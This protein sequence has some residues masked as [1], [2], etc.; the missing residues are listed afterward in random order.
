MLTKCLFFLQFVFCFSLCLSS[1]SFLSEE[2]KSRLKLLF[3]LDS[4][5]IDY[6]L[7]NI[8]YSL[9]GSSILAKDNLNSVFTTKEITNLCNHLKATLTGSQHVLEDIF[10]ASSSSQLL[11][12]GVIYFFH[13][14]FN[15][16]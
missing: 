7:A 3:K 14:T 4:N 5:L 15:Y 16:T 6:G 1:D 12:C 2:D 9:Q 10:F 8:Y 11:N 13:F